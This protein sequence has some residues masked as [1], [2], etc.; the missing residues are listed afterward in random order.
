MKLS[1]TADGWLLP[2][3]ARV[4]T[5]VCMDYALSL[6]MDDRCQGTYELRIE[7]EFTLCPA[8]GEPA[9]I[10][11]HV[12]PGRD[13]EAWTLAGPEG[14]RVVSLPGGGLSIFGD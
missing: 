1:P 2:L 10:V 11:L 8:A 13:Y 7:Q 12:A 3:S 5:R 14:L 6:D 4:V 9:H